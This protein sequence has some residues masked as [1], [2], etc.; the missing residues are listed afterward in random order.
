MAA[1]PHDELAQ[2]RF[3]TLPARNQLDFTRCT[4]I[5]PSLDNAPSEGKE[6][7]DVDQE[8]F[9]H[10]FWETDGINRSL[11]LDNAESA[12]RNL[13]GTQMLEIEHAD[14]LEVVE[15]RMG[16]LVLKEAHFIVV[17]HDVPMILYDAIQRRDAF[18]G[19]NVQHPRLGDEY[20][21]TIHRA[22]VI[23]LGI[24]RYENGRLAPQRF[25]GV[26]VKVVIARLGTDFCGLLDHCDDV[27]VFEFASAEPAIETECLALDFTE[28]VDGVLEL[29]ATFLDLVAEFHEYHHLLLGQMTRHAPIHRIRRRFLLPHLRHGE[30]LRGRLGQR[31]AVGGGDRERCDAT[32]DVVMIVLA[33]HQFLGGP[34]TGDS[35]HC[36]GRLL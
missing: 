23:K 19:I 10:S 34:G 6:S 22:S 1:G 31:T 4:R 15:F 16:L 2:P 9:I 30:S 18:D 24:L 28:G 35:G 3:P 17:H 13:G 25:H 32:G 26:R 14:A 5:D 11:G 8:H 20:R 33:V 21:T 12:L 27:I 36:F 7:R 29:A